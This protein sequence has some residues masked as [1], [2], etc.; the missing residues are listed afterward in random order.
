MRKFMRRVRLTCSLVAAVSMGWVLAA[1]GAEPVGTLKTPRLDP[2]VAV[3]RRAACPPGAAVRIQA[4]PR[5]ADAIHLVRYPKSTSG[6]LS[7][8]APQSDLWK[9]AVPQEL[10]RHG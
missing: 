9:V 6:G 1:F 2:G 4:D 10:L 8:I 3:E 5:G 7:S